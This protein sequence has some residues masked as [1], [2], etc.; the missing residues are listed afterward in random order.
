MELLRGHVYLAKLNT[1]TPKYYVVVSNNQRN[2][3]FG[4]ALVVRVTST[5]KYTELDSVVELPPGEFLTGW[6]RCD[7]LTTLYD[8]EP[9][10]DAGQFSANAMHAI[11]AGL[12]ATLGM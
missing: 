4:D 3:S 9:I 2:R 10:K 12:R 1:E 11:E 8:D 5:D 6:A 7:N